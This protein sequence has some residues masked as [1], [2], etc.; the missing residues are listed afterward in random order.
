MSDGI[1][2]FTRS[3]NCIE[4][5]ACVS[6]CPVTQKHQQF[7]GPAVLAAAHN[8][9]KNFPEKAEELL[10]FARNQRGVNFCERALNC[11]RVCPTGVYPARHISPKFYFF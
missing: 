5:G 4:C 9:L 8:E 11:N 3:E 1:Q 2:Q 10:F 6:A 7:L